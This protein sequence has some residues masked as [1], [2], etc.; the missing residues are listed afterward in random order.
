MLDVGD[1]L[2]IQLIGQ[3]NYNE[4]FLISGN[5]SINLP[6]IGE[7][8]L[9]GLNI[10]EASLLIVTPDKDDV[11]GEDNISKFNSKILSFFKK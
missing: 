7:V 2:K 1:I 5:G 6:D 10:N 9:A 8:I 4:E 11:Y 3:E